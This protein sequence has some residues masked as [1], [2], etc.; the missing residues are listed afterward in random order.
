MLV[1]GSSGLVGRA[2][3]AELSALGVEVRGI[4]RRRA[5]KNTIRADLSHRATAA[6]VVAQVSP[7]AVIHL[8]GAA[9]GDRGELHQANVVATRNLLEAV[10]TLDRPPPLIVAGSAAEYGHPLTERVAE[11][12]AT[13]PV[14]D[15]GRSKLE[16]SVVARQFAH[17][18]GLCLCVVRPFNIV[19]RA[20]PTTS[21]LGNMRGQ[22]VAGQGPRRAI[23]CGR[24]D[25]VRDFV[26]LEFVV[27]A[28]VRLLELD[29]WP[30]TLNVCS[31]TGIELGEV[32]S[33]MASQ[34]GVEVIVSLI[35]ELAAIP[36]PK[37]IIG[38]ASLLHSY[39]L[40]CEPT[41]SSLARIMIGGGDA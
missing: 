10:S 16:Q 11:D 3:T 40:S 14:T 28:I 13:N 18:N 23:R 20:L 36:A 4:A 6:A 37:R 21:A 12:H 24:L 39:G 25:I 19:A 31:G 1:T 38:D 8:A 34:S 33:A 41:A 35:P 32:L 30:T 27:Q 22:L 9:H 26:P 2:V 17:E 5:S 7:T 15:Y 29:A